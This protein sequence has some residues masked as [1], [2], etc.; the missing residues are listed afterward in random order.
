MSEPTREELYA[1]FYEFVKSALKCDL[2]R[3]PTEEEIED[4]MNEGDYE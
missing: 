2:G 3:E 1:D 4:A